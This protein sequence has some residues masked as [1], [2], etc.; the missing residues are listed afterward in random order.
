[1]VVKSTRSPFG[2]G[3]T[4][5]YRSAAKF[6]RNRQHVVLSAVLGEY[7][8]CGHP[9]CLQ[10]HPSR[11]LTAKLAAYLEFGSRIQAA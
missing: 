6:D 2:N 9:P 10:R 3:T 1:M 11:V 8:N 7:A 5:F 4:S